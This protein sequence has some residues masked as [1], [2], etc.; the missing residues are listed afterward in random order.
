MP[1]YIINALSDIQ[2]VLEEKG[3]TVS[4]QGRWPSV[5]HTVGFTRTYKPDDEDLSEAS[6][7]EKML[8]EFMSMW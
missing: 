2:N 7:E 5:S 8:A 4:L 6:F 1:T 3:Q